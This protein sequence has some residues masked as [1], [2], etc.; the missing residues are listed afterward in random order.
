MYVHIYTYIHSPNRVYTEGVLAVCL[1]AGWMRTRVRT[2]VRVGQLLCA[3][4]GLG[5]THLH[6][7][8]LKHLFFIC[9]R[10][11]GFDTFCSRTL[12]EPWRPRTASRILPDS[13]FPPYLS[14]VAD[15]L[16]ETS[17]LI[18]AFDEKVTRKI[19]WNI[20]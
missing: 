19:K 13:K 17:L 20:L 18:R 15:A 11:N 7:S 2:G 6:P 1:V 4:C 12:V 5:D 10:K 16:A 9:I 8:Q 14:C 3:G